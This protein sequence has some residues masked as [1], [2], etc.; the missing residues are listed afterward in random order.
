VCAWNHWGQLYLNQDWYFNPQT[1]PDAGSQQ[2]SINAFNSFGEV[3]IVYF[4]LDVAPAGFAASG[5]GS[6][7]G[8]TYPPGTPGAPVATGS[9]ARSGQPQGF[10]N[11]L[12][13]LTYSDAAGTQVCGNCSTDPGHQVNNG[14][15][16]PTA[17]SPTTGVGQ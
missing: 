2:C 7:D 13:G 3:A 8:G 1:W 12:T 16:D 11:P 4:S 5:G 6:V 10:F 17:S 9:S 14:N 15:D